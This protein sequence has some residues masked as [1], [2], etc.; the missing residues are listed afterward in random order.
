MSIMECDYEIGHEWF[1]L[2]SLTYVA[3]NV[4]QKDKASIVGETIEYIIEL[5][6]TVKELQKIKRRK[7][8]DDGSR[9]CSDKTLGVQRCKENSIQSLDPNSTSHVKP[10]IAQINQ[11]KSHQVLVPTS[12]HSN[13]IVTN[14]STYDQSCLHT[15]QHMREDVKVY[16]KLL[17]IMFTWFFLGHEIF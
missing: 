9:H 1:L 16:Y 5:E 12:N 13:E 15:S 10:V 17:T 4:V 3:F 7:Y 14:M 6:N 11:E 8:E 2:L